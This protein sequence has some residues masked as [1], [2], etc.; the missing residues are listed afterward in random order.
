MVGRGGVRV[1][2]WSAG[3]GGGNIPHS[4]EGT[5]HH[6]DPTTPATRSILCH[7]THPLRHGTKE[8]H[9]RHP[10]P[11]RTF[12][13]FCRCWHKGDGRGATSSAPKW[14]VSSWGPLYSPYF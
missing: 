9:P 7:K 14:V 3:G 1:G 12:S 13:A 2:G 5:T 10:G 11:F 8:H 6:A 4:L